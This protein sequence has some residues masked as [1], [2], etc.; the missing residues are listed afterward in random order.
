MPK[1]RKGSFTTKRGKLYARLSW[2]DEATGERRERY[3]Q[4]VN[5]TEGKRWMKDQLRQ[6]DD[7]GAELLDAEQ[8]T[9]AEL[10]DGYIEAHVYEAEIV[11]GRKVA[12]LKSVQPVLT[13]LKALQQHL[14]RKP[15]QSITH[16]DLL[17]Y[18]RERLKTKTVRGTS[19]SITTVNRELQQAR[20]VL[21]FAIRQGWV[22]RNPFTVGGNSLISM[23]DEVRRDR[24]LT[25]DEEDRLLA[26]CIGRREH[27]RAIVIAAMDTAARRGELLKLK[28]RA[29]DLDNRIIVLEHS[30][31]KTAKQRLVPITRRLEAE[32][33]RLWVAATNQSLGANVF[34]IG[35]QSI[36]EF[37]RS[38]RTACQLASITGL[39][40]HDLRHCATTKM[41]NAGLPAEHV[42]AAT[43]HTQSS[44]FRR[45]IN[46]DVERVQSIAEALDAM[47]GKDADKTLTSQFIH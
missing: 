21:N 38:F 31:T 8:L 47:Q 3:K 28:W 20:A 26:V 2:V 13:C 9:F 22:L 5:R 42:M 33:R 43:G 25:A 14:G 44:T 6:L 19:R 18:K 27:L 12:G 40:F 11:N 46:T 4:V 10:I 1:E 45:Y 35:G 41:V 7:Y 17:K 24:V 32:L 36:A 23:A 29:V 34:T 39:T 30:T 16:A 15:V 37:K